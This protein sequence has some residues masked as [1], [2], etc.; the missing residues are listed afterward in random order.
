[1]NDVVPTNKRK[2]LGYY[3]W[4]VWALLI[5]T[6]TV[7]AQDPLV[8]DLRGNGKLSWTNRFTNGTYTL[9]WA[10]ELSGSWHDW[11]SYTHATPTNESMS[12]DVPMYFR[13]L[14]DTNH[15]RFIPP[16]GQILMM[17]GQDINSI[18]QYVD[19]TGIEPGGVMLYTS[20]MNAEGLTN[21]F[22]LGGGGTQHGQYL[23]DKYS[24][25]AL[26]IGLYMVGELPDIAEGY[27]DDSIDKLGHW[28]ESTGRMV[29]LRIGYE[30]DADWTAYDTNLYV[31]AYR[32][33]VNRYRALHIDNIAYVWNSQGYAVRHDPMAWYPGDAYVD[34][35]GVSMF[36]N[37]YGVNKPYVD[38][39]V[40]IAENL[41]K[42][43]MIA[44]SSPHGITATNGV[45]SW[46]QWYADVFKWIAENDVKAFCY[47]NCDWDATEMWQ[48]NTLGWGDCRVQSDPDVL[49]LWMYTMTNHPFIQGNTP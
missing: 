30:F 17:V 21:A 48:F 33:I 28:I 22:Y 11:S 27:Y 6:G 47:I 16:D 46:T 10:S 1:M 41:N 12:I 19:A 18:D 43:L 49:A 15:N 7:M 45:S 37:P 34:W 44:E 2:G 24:N 42:P 38:R 9:K 39:I 25:S 8:I 35:V 32:R 31:R 14:I 29:F 23:V 13:L 4:A 36:G 5:M 26:Q 20:A 3:G 40:E